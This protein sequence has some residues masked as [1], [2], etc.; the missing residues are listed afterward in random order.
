MQGP[1]H[2]TLNGSVVL[3]TGASGGIGAELAR[4]LARSYSHPAAKPAPNSTPGTATGTDHTADHTAATPATIR[5]ALAARNTEKL[6]QVTEEC[7]ALGA[8]AISVPGDV[9]IE[10]DCRSIVARTVNH[11]GRLDVLINNA[12]LG[13]SAPFDEIT[14]LSIFE[15]L[16]RVNFHGS[17]WCTAFALPH[18]K[19]SK[20]RIVAVSSLTGLTGV[21]RRS[22]YA[23]TKHAM[24]GFFDTLRIELA[25]TG[26]SVTV[27]YPGFV[28]S[29]I[30]SNALS[31]DGTP[32]GA[33]PNQRR[34]PETMD[35]D[36]CARIILKA[37]EQRKR[38]VV[39]TWRGKIGRIMKM[40]A[41]GLVDRMTL[42]VMNRRR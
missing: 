24:A 17:V 2:S 18:L 16:M 20:G 35:T 12:G 23:A 28:V 21:P 30:N 26:V 11:F 3:I 10:D 32:Y 31:A 40:L 25:P 36:V 27:I 14:D 29:D 6:D 34:L 5:I 37:V 33:R 1:T 7:R 41:P 13:A 38:E 22:A 39:M 8:D 19:A 4:Q 9:S 15:R 42:R